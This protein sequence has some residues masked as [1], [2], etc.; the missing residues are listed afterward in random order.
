MTVVGTFSFNFQVVFPLFVTRD[1]GSSTT[2]FTLL[3]SVVSFGALLG[4]LAS[5]RRN[6]VEVR[7]VAYAAMAFG[8]ALGVTAVVPSAPWAFV[9]GLFI[10]LASITFLTTS[11]ALVQLRAAPTMRGRVL[12]LQAIVFLGSTPI[13]GPIVG[14]IAEQWGARWSI[15]VGAVAA[16]GAGAWGLASAR[17]VAAAA[18]ESTPTEPPESGESDDERRLRLAA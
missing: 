8:A 9:M 1:L 5:A 15:A 2:T 18:G 6:H 11:T 13:G 7:H 14:A 4:A 10:G 16:L 12:A 3:F 17:R